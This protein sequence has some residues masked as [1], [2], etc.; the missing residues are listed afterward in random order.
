MLQTRTEITTLH[1]V[2]AHA[3]ITGNEQADKLA[4]LGCT[5][6]HRNAIALYEHAHPT[7]YYLQKKLVALDARHTR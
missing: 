4:K 1:K 3:N 7:P 2:R 5:L 6:E